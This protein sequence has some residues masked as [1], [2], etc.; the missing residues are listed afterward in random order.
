MLIRRTE[1][2]YNIYNIILILINVFQF[3][4]KV[5][6]IPATLFSIGGILKMNPSNNILKSKKLVS[7]VL[8]IL[9]T[10]TALTTATTVSNKSPYQLDSDHMSYTFAFKEPTIQSI[11]ADNTLYSQVQMLGCLNL[12]KRAG[13]PTLPVKFIQLLLPYGTTVASVD[14]QGTPVQYNYPRD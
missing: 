13:E 8:C 4:S 1:V 7:V 11:T 5:L 12:G 6:I 3:S 10:M 2:S 9:F 14:V